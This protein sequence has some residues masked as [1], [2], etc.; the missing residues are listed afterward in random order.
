M[1]SSSVTVY[2][3]TQTSDWCLFP[4]LLRFAGHVTID[5]TMHYGE[6]HG[7]SAKKA[8]ERRNDLRL[9][10]LSENETFRFSV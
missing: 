6:E 4:L 10:K 3:L 1:Y 9:S 7:T 8:R 5:Y 2:V